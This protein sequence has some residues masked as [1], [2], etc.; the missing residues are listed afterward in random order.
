MAVNNNALRFRPAVPCA[1]CTK[2][3]DRYC[4]HQTRCA[5]CNRGRNARLYRARKRVDPN[6][7]KEQAAKN[8]AR[9]LANPE[10]AAL[11][12]SR[13]Q[14]KYAYATARYANP[15][16]CQDCGK[17]E[18]RTSGRQIVCAGCAK[19]KRPL[20]ARISERVRQS[21]IYGKSASWTKLVDYTVNDLQRHLERQFARGMTWDNFGE[22]HIDHIIPI[23]RFT[24]SSVDDEQ[25][26]Q[27]WSLTNLRPLW[28]RENISKGARRELLL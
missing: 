25:F 12:R 8:R 22:W 28:A 1:D 27:C 24:F 17:T 19:I 3:F 15:L 2:P 21:L 26:K 18:P 14:E 11:Y 6:W 20:S 4:G 13:R 7:R 23:A 10:K 9:L 16:V 5:D